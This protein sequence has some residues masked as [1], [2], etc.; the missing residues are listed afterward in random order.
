MLYSYDFVSAVPLKEYTVDLRFGVLLWFHN[1]PMPFRIISTTHNCSNTGE[2]ASKNKDEWVTLIQQWFW[3]EQNE[4]QQKQ[5][6]V[7]TLYDIL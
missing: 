2:A 6:P 4:V 1:L 5:D 7:H 3:Y